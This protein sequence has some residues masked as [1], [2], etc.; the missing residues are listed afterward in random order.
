VQLIFCKDEVNFYLCDDKSLYDSPVYEDPIQIY[1]ELVDT[2]AYLIK[3]DTTPGLAKNYAFDLY[4]NPGDAD[5][6]TTDLDVQ[7]TWVQ[8]RSA[9][10]TRVGS[11]VEI[12]IELRGMDGKRKKRSYS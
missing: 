9:I 5:A 11:P 6:S 3:V 8:P 1:D 7:K 4:G 10:E 12:Q 2:A